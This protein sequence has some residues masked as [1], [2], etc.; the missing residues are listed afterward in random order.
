MKIRSMVCIIALAFVT[1]CKKEDGTASAGDVGSS[2]RSRTGVGGVAGED[3]GSSEGDPDTKEDRVRQREFSKRLETAR[4]LFKE[5][6][7][8]SALTVLEEAGH[9]NES[10]PDLLYLR[11][12]CHV[13]QRDFEQALAD[14]SGVL[15]K[16]SH[17]SSIHFNIGEVHFVTKRWEDAIKSFKQARE[18]L[19]SEPTTLRQLIDF[20]LMLCEAGLGHREEFEALAETNSR[21]QGSPLA[22]YTKAVRA[23]QAEDADGA[24]EALKAIAEVFPDAKVRAPWDDTLTE[25]GYIPPAGK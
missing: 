2:S 3:R 8:S 21:E 25:F 12:S 15:K 19:G 5:H 9:L 23:L 7:V 18:L 14:F 13:E 22:E 6:D 20:K 1:S 10:H 17:N 11:G 24:G 16:A 4:K